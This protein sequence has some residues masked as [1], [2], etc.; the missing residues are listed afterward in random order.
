ME[1]LPILFSRPMVQEIL[2]RWTI[3]TRQVLEMPR[4]AQA[5]GWSARIME[6]QELDGSL[7]WC[8]SDTDCAVKLPFPQSGDRLYV[9]EAWKTDRAY[10]NHAPSDMGG[11][12]PVFYMADNAVERFGGRPDALS[13]W[14]RLRQGRHMPR[15]ASRM[16]LVVTD[17]KVE[18]LQ[19]ISEQDAKV[20]GV[21]QVSTSTDGKG[22]GWKATYDSQARLSAIMAFRDLWDSLNASRGFGWEDNPWVVAATYTVHK[23]NIDQV[24]CAA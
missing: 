2:K 22:S 1:D 7:V 20:Q 11:E 23:C 14:G 8:G 17:V 4:W 19:D 5:D 6:A 12:K 13:R 9:R 18:R 24:A 16:T 21:F 3:S 10:D 15:W